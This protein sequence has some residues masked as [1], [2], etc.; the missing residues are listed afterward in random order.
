MSIAPRHRRIEIRIPKL[1]ISNKPKYS[2]LKIEI[3]NEIVWN[4]VFFDHLDLF[5][6]SGFEFRICNFT[7]TWRAW[8][9]C[10]SHFFPIP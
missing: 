4:F 8:R 2:N 5:R 10:G 1:E 6:I 3:Q 9:L 7:Y